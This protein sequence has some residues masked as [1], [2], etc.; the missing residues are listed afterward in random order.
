MLYY[1]KTYLW[2]NLASNI[3]KGI[4]LFGTGT[5][6]VS[7]FGMVK[8]IPTGSGYEMVVAA[9]PQGPLPVFGPKDVS[10]FFVKPTEGVLTSEFGSRWGREHHGIDIGGEDGEKILAADSGR[11]VY[12]GWVEGYG[13]Y[14][15]IDH[16]NGFETA[17]AHC[18]KLAVSE[19]EYVTQGQQIACMGSTGNSTGPH[20]HFEVKKDGEYLDPLRYVLY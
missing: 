8:E 15:S 20:L 2:K 19:G 11:V 18:S 3:L 10:T 9:E 7:M 17:Y 4:F 13:N 6:L 14:L 16:E 12:A 1:R 5:A